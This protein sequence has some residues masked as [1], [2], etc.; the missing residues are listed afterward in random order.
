VHK[1]TG[2]GESL[3]DLFGLS[4][5]CR[6]Q[7]YESW[8]IVCGL[9]CCFCFPSINCRSRTGRKKD[10]MSPSAQSPCMAAD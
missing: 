5:G 10:P 9:V 4:R 1:K 2:G 3:D 6:L 7:D 8:S